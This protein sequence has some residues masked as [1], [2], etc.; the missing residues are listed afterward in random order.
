MLL[1]LEIAFSQVIFISPNGDDNNPGSKQSPVA[2]LNRATQIAREIRKQPK[3][4]QP[5][6]IKIG[7]GQYFMT[8][9]LQLNPSDGGPKNSPFVF[10]GEGPT[11]PIFYGGRKLPGFKKISDTLWVA[12]ISGINTKN[13]KNFEQLYVNGERA[14]R[15]QSPDSGFFKPVSVVQDIIRKGEG[16]VADSAVQKIKLS[17]QAFRVLENTSENDL[18][19]VVITFNHHWDNT[20]KKISSFNKTDSSISITGRAMKNHNPITTKS[21]FVIQNIKSGLDSPGEW[22]LSD[23]A[24]LY[25]YPRPGEIPNNTDAI[26][27][28]LEKLV[29]IQGIGMDSV[30]SNITFENI[31]FQV[32]AYTLPTGGFEPFQSAVPIQAAIELNYANNVS[33]KNCE[34]KHTGGSAIWFKRGCN[35]GLVSS[36]LIEDLGANAIKIGETVVPKDS[37]ALTSHV[38]VENN[39]IRTGGQFFPCAAGVIILKASDNTL[40]HNDISNFKYSGISVGWVWGYAPSPSKRNLIEFNHIHHLGWGELS[41]MGGIYTLGESDGTLIQNNRIHHVYS[42][43]YGGWGIYTD[44]GSSGITIQNNLVYHCKNAGFHQHYGK[45]NLIKNNIF[46]NNWKAQLQASRVEKHQSFIFTNNI[47][48][49]SS[50]S[51]VTSVWDKADIS[52]D[53]NC[54]WDTRNT[55]PTFGKL[56]LNAWQ[57]SGKDTHSVILNPHFKNPDKFDYRFESQDVLRKIQF[58]PFDYTKCGVYGSPEWK[59]KSLLPMN[60]QMKFDRIVKKMERAD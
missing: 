57:R 55:E 27:P 28:T 54:Y 20:I 8:E 41:D 47:V 43:E 46:A 22:Y 4:N 12:D 53:Y 59:K 13:T 34:I 6:V 37:N 14:V 10:R 16:R 7:S 23:S 50:G 1:Q 40:R 48:Y 49:Y 3:L 2:S 30:V 19:D 45:N 32:S 38:T 58:K 26:V 17:Q 5:I 18:K 11:P 24:K 56:S 36:C 25:Y 15:A 31:S 9:T 33:F 29:E 52:T 42:S 51:L 35:L 44:E 21:T 60:L 39:I